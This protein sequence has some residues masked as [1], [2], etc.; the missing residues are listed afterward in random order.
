MDDRL[1]RHRQTAQPKQQPDSELRRT[2]PRAP[3]AH[4]CPHQSP[5]DRV[6]P[7]DLL[8]C[9]S[10]PGSLLSV[11]LL[12]HTFDNQNPSLVIKLITM[13]SALVT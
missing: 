5:S 1:C 6:H 4:A 12:I 9:P 10:H 7:R 8:I 2:P 3:C 13:K 11:L